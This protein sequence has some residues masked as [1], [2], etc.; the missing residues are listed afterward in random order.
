MDLQLAVSS[1][2][3]CSLTRSMAAG[4]LL[5]AMDLTL[6]GV[7]L[8]VAIALGLVIFVHEL[9]HFA[10][11]KW[12]GV[13]CEKFYLGFDFFGLKLFRFRWGETEYGI[14]VFPLGGYVKMLGQEDNPARLQAEIERAKAAEGSKADTP[15]KEA[16]AD[17]GAA[18]GSPAQDGPDPSP[19]EGEGTEA[20]QPATAPA[21]PS[22]VAAAE[23]A[24][25]DPRSYLSKSVPQRMAIISAGVIMNLIFAFLC[26]VLAY[27]IG[28]RQIECGVGALVAGAPAWE[29]GFEVGDHVTA[30]G[31]EPVKSFNDLTERVVLGE[32]DKP[33]VF[34][35]RRPGVEEPIEISVRPDTS[36]G[37]PAI[38]VSSPNLPE[39]ASARRGYLIGLEKPTYPASV[40]R[41]ADPGFEFGDRIMAIDGEITHDYASIH[42]ILAARPDQPLRFLIERREDAA[43]DSAERDGPHPEGEGTSGRRRP[44]ERGK[45]AERG[46]IAERVEITVAPQRMKRLGLVMEIGPV[47]AV[48][49]DSPAAEA[50]IEPGEVITAIDGQ[51]VGDPLTLADRLRTRAGETITLTLRGKPDA[52][53][54]A[55]NGQGDAATREVTLTVRP[56]TTFTEPTYPNDPVSVPG[57]GVAVVVGKRIAAIM[58]DSP[59]SKSEA[60][61]LLRPGRKVVALE[62]LPIED[63]GE[64]L[65]TLGLAGKRTIDLREEKNQWPAA[66]HA[67]QQR[68][69]GA[70]VKVTVVDAGGE[71]TDAGDDNK[72]HSVTLTPVEMGDF[73]LPDRGLVFQPPY[74]VRTADG[75]GDALVLGWE[76]S[77]GAVT[78][79]FGFIQKLFSQ[80]IS[81][82]ML[83][84]PI[85]IARAAGRYAYEGFAAFLIFLTLLGVN[86]AV[87]NFLP[88]PLLDGG[89]FVFLAYE[90]IRGKPADERVQIILTY[91][92]LAFI[93]G[94]MLWVTGLDLGLISRQ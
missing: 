46:E 64:E 91:V 86:L 87:L 69:E 94:L 52:E 84:G 93:L 90:G 31:G 59:A 7:I 65:E 73:Y 43:G 2:I 71:G 39:M 20:N 51:P 33:T 53:D 70:G 9:G 4:G 63:A 81:A 22:A 26:A 62:L 37:R 25:Y 15:A 11:A 27:V 76:E 34:T 30:I 35:V 36:Q 50:G 82:R 19:S 72:E 16:E 56:T 75:L 29:A 12:C 67:M 41:A 58:P 32:T 48:Q 74:F 44:A 40:A 83:G 5:A 3:D 6:I 1:L 78:Q 57:L 79:V 60:A 38:G 17:T 14:G 85:T 8:Q 10:V 61:K 47:Q 24:L 55:N 92:G 18:G 21:G 49:V 80:D 88:I 42:R 77:V 28:V 13:K 66:F 89:H 54:D 68:P 23:Q 45:I